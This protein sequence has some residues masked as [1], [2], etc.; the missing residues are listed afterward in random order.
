[1]AKKKNLY[2]TQVHEA[3]VYDFDIKPNLQQDF[4]C[5]QIHLEVA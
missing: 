4:P 5:Y 2:F 3:V 1:M